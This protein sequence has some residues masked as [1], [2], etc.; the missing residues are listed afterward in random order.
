MVLV[1]VVL[2]S[3]RPFKHPNALT[4]YLGNHLATRCFVDPFMSMLRESLAPR[5]FVGSHFVGHSE[6]SHLLSDEVS[7]SNGGSIF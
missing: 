2:C 6:V 5:E 1:C 3:N 4:T 7:Y